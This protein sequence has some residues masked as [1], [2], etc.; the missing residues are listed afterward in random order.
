MLSVTRG[1]GVGTDMGRGGYS[2]LRVTSY[3]DIC[4]A[5]VIGNLFLVSNVERPTILLVNA[6]PNYRSTSIFCY[7]IWRPWLTNGILKTKERRNLDST[8]QNHTKVLPLLTSQELPHGGR[9][10]KSISSQIPTCP[11]HIRLR[12][13]PLLHLAKGPNASVGLTHKRL[14]EEIDTAI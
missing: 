10:P 9:S 6:H 12:Q 11:R 5:R 14:S 2:L 7:L 3:R 1:E 4:R 13:R 8:F